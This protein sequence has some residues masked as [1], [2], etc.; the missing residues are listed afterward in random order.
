MQ[1]NGAQLQNLR[2]NIFVYQEMSLKIGCPN[3]SRNQ[4]EIFYRALLKKRSKKKRN[5]TA[6]YS[7]FSFQ[8]SSKFTLE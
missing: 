6:V 5:F 8:K 1:N 2:M 7:F 4:L 3:E